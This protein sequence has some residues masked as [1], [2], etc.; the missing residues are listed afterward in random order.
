MNRSTKIHFPVFNGY[1]VRVIVARSMAAT[2]RR[3][4]EPDLK[5]AEAAF[6]YKDDKPYM[7]WLIVQPNAGADLLAHE[8]SHAVNHLAAYLGTKFDEETF[9][10]HLGYLVGRIH[11]FIK[12]GQ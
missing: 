3:L 2:G 8:A 1:E 10:H 5:D 11:K 9:A 7:G 6:V 4:K 12:R